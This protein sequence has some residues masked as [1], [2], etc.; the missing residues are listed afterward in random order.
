[1]LFENMLVVVI[2]DYLLFQ[3]FF[4][5]HCPQLNSNVCPHCMIS[6]VG[7]FLWEKSKLLEQSALIMVSVLSK[8]SNSELIYSLFLLSEGQNALILNRKMHDNV[9]RL[10][11]RRYS[12]IRYK[13]DTNSL[14][15]FISDV[16]C[17]IKCSIVFS[18]KSR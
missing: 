11:N 2:N 15:V 13:M 8:L 7:I 5:H 4:F 16:N 6:F 3:A 9:L 18:Q 1:M 12:V 10:V 14:I 17:K